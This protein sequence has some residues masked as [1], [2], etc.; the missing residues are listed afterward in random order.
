MSCHRCCLGV[1]CKHLGLES[2]SACVS[3]V[4]Q[5]QPESAVAITSRCLKA[6]TLSIQAQTT[7][8]VYQHWRVCASNA[9]Q[10]VPQALPLTLR[11]MTVQQRV[12]KQY[13][14]AL[15]HML[16]PQAALH[17][18]PSV[19]LA[20]HPQ[21]WC[22]LPSCPTCIAH[23]LVRLRHGLSSIVACIFKLVY[24]SHLDA[25]PG[26][27]E[28]LDEARRVQCACGDCRGC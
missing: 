2:G 18:L 20:S 1:V 17:W 19:T 12:Y 27:A 11:S 3:S 24:P 28:R 16:I 26:R 9:Q 8:Q 14:F 21:A 5:S 22:Q 25:S 13:V 6:V 23:N 10:C 4:F 15:R 7:S